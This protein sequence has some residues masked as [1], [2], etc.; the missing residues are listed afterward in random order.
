MTNDAAPPPSIPDDPPE[1][2]KRI[3]FQRGGL[4]RD[5][6]THI[7]PLY[8]RR[9]AEGA[10]DR[11]TM[12]FRV[13]PHMCNPAGTLHGGMM[14]SVA[15]LIGGLGAAYVAGVRRD[16]Y[17]TINMTFDFVAPARL[18]DWV[19]GRPEVVRATRSMIFSHIYLTVGATRI[20]RAS[21]IVKIPSGDGWRTG[22]GDGAPA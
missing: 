19:E 2:F 20:L 9:G 12:G 15:D 22:R 18:G 6:N 8:A 5:Y 7:G 13:Q 16:F 1:G 4:P 10:A 14:M 21:A 3:D 17:P 11:F